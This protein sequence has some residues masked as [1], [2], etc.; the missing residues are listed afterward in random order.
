MIRDVSTTSVILQFQS[1]LDTARQI[2][3]GANLSKGKSSATVDDKLP[4]HASSKVPD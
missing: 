1:P 4:C 3:L 2:G